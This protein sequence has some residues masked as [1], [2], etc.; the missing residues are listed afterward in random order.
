MQD[1]DVMDIDIDL[2]VDIEPTPLVQDI[3]PNGFQMVRPVITARQQ[4]RQLR[5]D[6]HSL[7][8]H[9]SESPTLVTRIHPTD[10]VPAV[11][12]DQNYPVPTSVNLQGVDDFTPDD[13]TEYLNEHFRSPDFVKV[14]WVND[15]SLNYVFK[16]ADAAANALRALTSNEMIDPSAVPVDTS[17]PAKPYSKKPAEVLGVRQA[18][19][20]DVK[21]KDAYKYSTWHKLNV[22]QMDRSGRREGGRDRR[23]NRRD[24]DD[25]SDYNR[26]RFDDAEHNRRRARNGTA[27]DLF[28]E[29]MYDDGPRSTRSRSGIDSYDGRRSSTHSMQSLSLDGDSKDRSRRG[30]HWAPPTGP[31]RDRGRRDDKDYGRLR[32]RSASPARSGDGRYGFGT[33]DDARSRRR[34]RSPARRRNG[35]RD[36]RPAERKRELFPA[37]KPT[38]LLASEKRELFVSEKREL[39]APEKREL[40]APEKREL[41]SANS[42][43]ELFPTVSEKRELIDSAPARDGPRELF[44]AEKGSAPRELFGKGPTSP[45]HRRTDATDETAKKKSIFDRITPKDSVPD[46][47]VQGNGNDDAGFS[48][49]GSA[50]MGGEIRIKGRGGPRMRAFDFED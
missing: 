33:D 24:I 9:T 3:Q 30:D 11:Y 18:H 5:P 14:A 27:G 35:R 21:K 15:T 12:K 43:S 22:G 20:G 29:D 49:R 10:D 41:F 47:N 16:T 40:F 7:F 8:Q 42:R 13:A 34:S 2:G 28:D 44:S 31:R 4:Y 48:I 1:E 23:R 50:G 46:S 26:N 17:R 25:P 37:D 45:Y 38:E 6:L 32:D 36:D 39:F 19:S